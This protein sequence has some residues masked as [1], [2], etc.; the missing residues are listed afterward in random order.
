M[1]ATLPSMVRLEQPIPECRDEV[2]IAV[3]QVLGLDEDVR[4]E[5]IP[6][7]PNTPASRPRLLKVSSFETPTMR[8]ASAVEGV[9]FAS[10][11]DKR[12]S[13][14]ST[15]ARERGSVEVAA[16]ATPGIQCLK[17]FNISLCQW[18]S[19]VSR[20]IHSASRR[21]TQDDQGADLEAA[22]QTRHGVRLCSPS[23]NSARQFDKLGPGTRRLRRCTR[24][25]RAASPARAWHRC[26]T[27]R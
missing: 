23:L 24:S 26:S 9:P 17:S 11:L 7:Q 16:T 6:R 19:N 27:R 20:S 14:A 22:R 21:R 10:A 18:T 12:P 4:V 5:Q 3:V 13:E 25:P 8:K 15:Y 2:E 1:L